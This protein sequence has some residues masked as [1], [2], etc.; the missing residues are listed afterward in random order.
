[1]ASRKSSGS[2]DTALRNARNLK[3]PELERWAKAML[4][5]RGEEDVVPDGWFTESELADKFDLSK[6]GVRP[7][8]QQLRKRNGI[9]ER[10]FR[11]WIKGRTER[12]YPI[13]YFKLK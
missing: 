10:K 13:T 3:D 5:L 6:S 12:R 8:I 4:D 11:R 7:Y 1:M 9:E 2:V